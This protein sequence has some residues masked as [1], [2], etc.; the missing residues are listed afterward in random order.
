MKQISLTLVVVSLIALV[1]C[2]WPWLP[3][4][5]SPTFEFTATD[6]A[7]DNLNDMVVS[8]VPDGKGGF[9]I[10]RV[11][12]VVP[13][14]DLVDVS[15]EAAIDFGDAEYS[16]VDLAGDTFTLYDTAYTGAW[17]G[18]AG[19]IAFG[20]EAPAAGATHAETVGISALRTDE[21]EGGVTKAVIQNSTLVVDWAGLTTV[22]TAKQT[23]TSIQV[24][25]ILDSNVDATPGIIDIV[26]ERVAADLKVVTV[27]ISS[28]E[29]GSVVTADPNTDTADAAL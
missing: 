17:V 25:A 16:L 15:G 6:T 20:D 28:A 27:G 10:A 7:A 26:Y 2:P 12:G 23:D 14:V 19:T 8:Y 24:Q 13:A 11:S 1:G 9:D 21:V 22:T 29:E 3:E 18:N 5:E 4:T